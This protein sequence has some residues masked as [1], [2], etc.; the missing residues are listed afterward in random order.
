MEGRIMKD[1]YKSCPVYENEEYRLRLVEQQDRTDLLKVYADEK[2]VPFFNCDN[3]GGD[4]FYYTTEQRMAEAIDD[5]LW[6]YARK[7][8]VRW[9]IIDKR[10]QETI[11][12]IEL[13]HR[14]ADDFFTNCGLLRLDLRSDCETSRKIMRILALIMEQSF[15]LFQCNKIASK[16]IPAAK[17]RKTALKKLGF[18]ETAEKLVGHDGTEYGFYFV[19][20]QYTC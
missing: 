1:V 4:D 19:R 6:E 15:I 13:F 3:C 11:G 10:V 8:F 20:E 9:S 16:A 7:G 5:W 12:T 18:K 17:E 2:A 14:D